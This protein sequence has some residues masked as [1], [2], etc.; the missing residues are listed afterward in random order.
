M[1]TYVRL[2]NTHQTFSAHTAQQSA[3]LGVAVA[4]N[5]NPLARTDPEVWDIHLYQP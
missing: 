3:L 5:A 4:M 2:P 1:H